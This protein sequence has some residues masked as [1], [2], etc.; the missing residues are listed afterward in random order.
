MLEGI[1]ISHGSER[2]QVSQGKSPSRM[3]ST[4]RD[5]EAVLHTE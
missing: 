3:D 2:C 4:Q 5:Q 1:E